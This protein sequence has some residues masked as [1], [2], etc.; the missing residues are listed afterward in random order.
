[1]QSVCSSYLKPCSHFHLIK[2]IASMMHCCRSSYLKP[3]SHFH[4]I[5]NITSMMHCWRA[6]IEARRIE[7]K[8]T[9][10]RR[11]EHRRHFTFKFCCKK[12][13]IK[14][15]AKVYKWHAL[16]MLHLELWWQHFCTLHSTKCKT[17]NLKRHELHLELTLTLIPN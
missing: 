8:K 14:S 15:A 4:L 7:K 3:C 12:S 6:T 13:Q 10:Q 16:C 1:M 17:L 11:Q 5:K 2:N 9:T